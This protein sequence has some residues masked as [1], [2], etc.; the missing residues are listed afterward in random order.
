MPSTEEPVLAPPL[1]QALLQVARSTVAHSALHGRGLAVRAEAYPPPLR[2]VR[3]SF[4]TL[5]RADG[6]LRGCIGSC[7]PQR[8]L[9]EDVAYNAHAAAQMDPRFAPVTTGEL[10]GIRVHLSL[11][12]V[13]E[14]MVFRDEA[15]LL[16]QVRPGIDGLI[17]ESSGA[18]GTFL[19]AVWETLPEVGSF[20]RHLKAKAGLPPTHWS[21]D[22]VVHRYTV[23]S[24]HED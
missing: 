2:Q 1:R 7:W 12:S 16:A 10:P 21:E 5:C 6:Q 11:L 23:E 22:V 19:P 9:V 13:P 4:V 3:A 17:L 8:P 15:E 14:R 20:V 24:I 18:R